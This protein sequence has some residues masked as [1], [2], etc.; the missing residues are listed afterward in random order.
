MKDTDKRKQG[1]P[2]NRASRDLPC[3]YRLRAV[4]T[5]QSWPP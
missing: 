2:D 1:R 4:E 3:R 5:L